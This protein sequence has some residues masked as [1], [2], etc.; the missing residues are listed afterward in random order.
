MKISAIKYFIA[1]IFLAIFSGGIS[2]TVFPT[3]LKEGS[4]VS[5][6]KQASEKDSSRTE[7]DK[8]SEVK[9]FTADIASFQLSPLQAE[10]LTPQRTISDFSFTRTFYLKVPTPPPDFI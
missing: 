8:G 5:W 6:Q 1:L 4:F 9:E 10:I 3:F 7:N 2:V